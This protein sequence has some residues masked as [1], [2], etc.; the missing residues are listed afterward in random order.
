LH[1]LAAV[2]LN[3]FSIVVV[4]CA[5]LNVVRR[6]GISTSS[7]SVTPLF[8]RRKAPPS[9]HTGPISDMGFGPDGRRLYT[10]S[11]DATIRVWDV[12]TGA[13][14]D[15]LAFQSP[16][17]SLTLS[18]TGEFLVTSHVDSVGLSMWCDKSFFQQVFLDGSAP[19]RPFQMD[20]PKPM[21]EAANDVDQEK[22]DLLAMSQTTEKTVKKVTDKGGKR[23]AASNQEIIVPKQEG[24]ITMS[25]LP[26]GH[27]KNL[28]HLELVKER[29][30][31]KEA[32]QKPPSAPFFLQ[33]RQ[34]ENIASVADKT[35]D[36]AKDARGTPD[37]VE[38]GGDKWNTAWSDDEQEDSTEGQQ[39]PNKPESRIL[40]SGSGGT[41]RKAYQRSVLATSLQECQHRQT[42]FQSAT[43]LMADMGPSAI[44]MAMTELC[45][46]SHD[47]E[48][49]ELLILASKWLL[50][51]CQSRQ[52]F[53]AVNA[54]L[55]RFLYLHASTI[56]GI[57]DTHAT[58]ATNDENGNLQK[59]GDNYNQQELLAV[60]Q[61]LQA[62]QREA[63]EVL[64][65]KMQH[66]L[67]LLGHFSMMVQS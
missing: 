7:T 47:I 51:A 46:G 40:K 29:N 48:G 26:V 62:A 15:W 27:W 16:P 58:K 54:Y 36:N 52:R 21:S 65:G 49:I 59:R 20:A 33:W 64:R 17:T 37:Q 1:T 12:P 11:L 13:C 9:G 25:G 43:E 44:D 61:E 38:D 30:K 55:N 18:P 34:G 2:A 32:P 56:A 19:L 63:A 67:C 66:T 42:S 35:A 57:E 8:G 45:Y 22:R 60:I 3:D 31:P 53:E 14:V 50:E 6:L 39:A 10:S 4:D 23:K 24:L 28:F 41:K 5:A